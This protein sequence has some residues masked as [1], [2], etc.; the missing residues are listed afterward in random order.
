MNL[1]RPSISSNLHRPSVRFV[2]P[3]DPPTSHVRSCAPTPRLTGSPALAQTALARPPCNPSLTCLRRPPWP[4]L[5]ILPARCA[6]LY[7]ETSSSP[8]QTSSLSTSPPARDYR[9]KSHRRDAPPPA[10]ATASARDGRRRSGRRKRR[11][12]KRRSGFPHRACDHGGDNKQRRLHRCHKQIR[13]FTI[14]GS[15]DLIIR[16]E[17]AYEFA[18]LIPNY[19]LHVIEGANHCYTAHCREHS[20]DVVE[21][22]TSSEE[23]YGLMP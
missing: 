13:F 7:H 14:H 11:R 17:D 4:A 12:S 1:R 6:A 18:W 8:A 10:R 21:A 9:R 20:D 3:P 23:C 19:M 22:I 16:V 5:E 2:A 15:A